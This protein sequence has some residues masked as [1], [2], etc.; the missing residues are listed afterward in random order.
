MTRNLFFIAVALFFNMGA[1]AQDNIVKEGTR[2]LEFDT[3]ADA[4]AAAE[5]EGKPIFLDCYTS[6]CG[7]CKQMATR[8]FPQK[9]IGDFLNER[10]VCIKIDMEKGEGPDLA[11]RYGVRVYPTYLVIDPNG[12]MRH[13]V[14]GAIEGAGFIGVI[15]EAFDDQKALGLKIDRFNAGERDREFMF[16]LTNSLSRI[17]DER[18]ATV[19][20][21]L[22][23]SLSDE[24]RL[25]PDNWMLFAKADLSPS[26]SESDRYLHANIDAFR[27]SIGRNNVD[28]RVS[29]PYLDKLRAVV[30]R[31]DK[32]TTV[33]DIDRMIEEMDALNL[34]IEKVL[35][36]HANAAKLVLQGDM[37]VNG[38]K[39]LASDFVLTPESPFFLVYPA[40]KN[41][42]T[43]TQIEAWEKWGNKIRATANDP[44]L[45]KYLDSIL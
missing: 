6:W 2:W 34:N 38:Y 39:K 21:E 8:V 32:T 11:E 1:F 41:D 18:A 31:Q 42:M 24:E 16:N 3:F 5:S 29:K 44:A 12:D 40:R 37:G 20:N 28:E 25:S 33:A 23:R 27:N 9:E 4:L 19:A 15:S 26:G 45:I 14:I 43:E 22:F 7:P 17:Y 35:I 10:F 36:V 30:A 13:K